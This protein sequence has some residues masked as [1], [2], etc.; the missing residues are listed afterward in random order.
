MKNIRTDEKVIL[1]P[2]CQTLNSSAYILKSGGKKFVVKE[3]PQNAFVREA[4]ILAFLAHKRFPYVPK[5]YGT[6][7]LDGKKVIVQEFVAGTELAFDKKSI[8]GCLPQIARA[9][10]R[11]HRL[12]QKTKKLISYFFT[13]ERDRTERLFQNLRLSCRESKNGLLM[14]YLEKAAVPLRSLASFLNSQNRRLREMIAPSL[15]N[16]EAELILAPDKKIYLLDW[17]SADFGDNAF[18]IADL[19]YI[20][21]NLD[22]ARFIGLYRVHLKVSDDF[23]FRVWLW[24]AMICLKEY[25]YNISDFNCSAVYKKIPGN[26]FGFITKA[27]LEKRLQKL[28]R[29][30]LMLHSFK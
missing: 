4:K 22:L 18:D 12:T 13:A 5:Y 9:F 16:K 2:L 20:Y 11:L 28:D 8:S 17:E 14:G 1:Y 29:A 15:I 23:T 25:L 27:H 26:L 30:Y 10:A 21:E 3:R 24:L 6:A 7:Q 19:I